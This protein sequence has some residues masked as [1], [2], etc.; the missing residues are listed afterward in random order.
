MQSCLPIFDRHVEKAS[1][2]VRWTI[3]RVISLLLIA[4]WMLGCAAPVFAL[5]PGRLRISN[6]QTSAFP[7]NSFTLDLID[8]QGS[9][10]A[11]LKIEELL[12]HEDGKTFAASG[13]L[14]QPRGIQFSLAI[15]AGPGLGPIAGAQPGTLTQLDAVREAVRA[16]SARQTAQAGDFSLATNTGMQVI[17]GTSAQL[18]TRL[19]EYQPD[20]F[21][22]QSNL[23]SLST[24]LDLAVDRAGKDTQRPA[25]LFVTPPL[26]EH[27]AAGLPDQSARAAQLC[28]PV[29]VWVVVADPN[30]PPEGIQSLQALADSSGGK[31]ALVTAG[32][33]FP[34]LESWLKPF[35]QV[36]QVN[37]RSQ[38][39][40]SGEHTLSVDVS[41]PSLQLSAE[42]SLKFN[43]DVRA[44]NPMFINPPAQLALNWTR[45]DGQEIA[46]LTPASL[47]LQVLVEF[48]DQ[49]QRS[50]KATRLFVNDE[51]VAENTAPP[52]DR[53]EWNLSGLI[54]SGTVKLRV[55]VDD[56]L[57]LSG[58]SIEVPVDV[59]VEPK[60]SRS[61]LPHISGQGL[62]AVGAVLLA[63]IVLVLIVLGE[64]RLRGRQRKGAWLRE[65]DPVTQPVPIVQDAP[66]RPRKIGTAPVW[67]RLDRGHNAPARMVR[68]SNLES[69]ATGSP[70]LLTRQEVTF[71]S[72]SHL[73]VVAVEDS[74]VHALHARL[75][76]TNEG[77][78]LLSDEGSVAGTWV[79]FV[80]INGKGKRLQHGDLIH[81][82]RA[83]FR[84]ELN[85]APPQDEFVVSMVDDSL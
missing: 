1:K 47:A 7:N 16:W 15:N 80:K 13:L 25:I 61:A 35:R 14:L 42:Q 38:V 30:S 68:L 83:L 43:L 27:E 26:G 10:V 65:K 3:S 32:D 33:V 45:V 34:D 29:F 54:Q 18:A 77:D 6:M 23:F 84:F 81:M 46:V 69:S 44:P 41:R 71:G 28:V 21:K 70:V 4:A 58:S 2:G 56:S 55:E 12:I 9:F 63:G 62:I 78:F 72:D 31:L 82:G 57:G 75:T 39:Q 59:T 66:S 40:T 50:L 60:P 85:P 74:S 49:I 37:Y 76:R 67:P 17:R 73:V 11:N 8:G 51:L 36:Y 48:P 22:T 53:F 19:T 20:F 52:F 79:N 5:V 24:A 64:N